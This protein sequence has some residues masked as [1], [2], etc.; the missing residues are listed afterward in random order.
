[1]VADLENSTWKERFLEV[2]SYLTFVGIRRQIN[3]IKYI[4]N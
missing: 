4:Y 1:M 2:L 3:P